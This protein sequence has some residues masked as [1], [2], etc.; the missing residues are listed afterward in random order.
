MSMRSSEEMFALLALGWKIWLQ[1]TI[2]TDR[3]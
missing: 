2:S 3:R 1:E